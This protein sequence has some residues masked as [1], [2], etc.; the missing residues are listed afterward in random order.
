MA[1]EVA[2]LIEQAQTGQTA[3]DQQNA[4]K[5]SSKGLERASKAKPS[6]QQHKQRYSANRIL[7]QGS[8]AGLI[9]DFGFEFHR[10]L[11]RL[12]LYCSHILTH[13]SRTF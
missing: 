4:G 10:S 1:A 8:V 6:K 11:P 13:T 5:N 9:G 2:F 7:D 12:L 3:R